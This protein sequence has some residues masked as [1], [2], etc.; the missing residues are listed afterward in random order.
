MFDQFYFNQFFFQPIFAMRFF[1]NNKELRERAGEAL[2]QAAQR[3]AEEKAV[4]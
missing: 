3:R 1:T 4:P 2:R